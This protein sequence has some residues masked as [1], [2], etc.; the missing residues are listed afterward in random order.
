MSDNEK[1]PENEV[2]P[3]GDDDHSIEDILASI[4]RIISD[5]DE[6]GVE[7]DAQD[8]N[9]APVM[10]EPAVKEDLISVDD[11]IDMDDDVLELTEAMIED[12]DD[13]QITADDIDAMFGANLEANEEPIIE[14][15][16]VTE[17]EVVATTPVVEEEM[18]EV[19]PVV[20]MRDMEED[21]DDLLTSEVA[22]MAAGSLSKLSALEKSD[23]TPSSSVTVGTI[24]L[25]EI[26]RQEVRPILK[27]WLNDN[28]TTI[29]ERAVEKEISKLKDR[30]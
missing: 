23:V 29:V 9:D 25:D 7:D 26:V 22:A 14:E 18:V 6:E 4:R 10:A 16:A 2:T 24:S 1:N 17:P 11:A 5:D 21:N 12:N 27:Q 30:L 19:A 8:D 20:E 3:E 13:A 15:P 28:L